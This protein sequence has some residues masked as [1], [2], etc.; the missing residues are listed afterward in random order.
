MKGGGGPIGWNMCGLKPGGGRQGTPEGGCRAMF[1]TAGEPL[2]D[3][4]KC[5]QRLLLLLQDEEE[6][7]LA[8][9]E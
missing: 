1:T 7:L 5:W 2:E 3:R 9:L 8:G 6:E 4:L